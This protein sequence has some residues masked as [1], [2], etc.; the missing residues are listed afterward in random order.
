MATEIFN[1]PHFNENIIVLPNG[2]LIVTTFKSPGLLY[3][4]DLSASPRSATPIADLATRG[5]TGVSGLVDLGNGRIAV[6]GGVHTSFAFEKGSMALFIISLDANAVV[7]TIPVPD[8][9]IMNGMAPWPADANKLVA[10]DSNGRLILIDVT[11]RKVSIALEHESMGAQGVKLPPRV[12]PVGVNGV[13]ARGEY[14]Y[15]TNSCRGTFGRIRVQ[16]DAV[17]EEDIEILATFS[18]GE[19]QVN[20][21]FVFDGQGNAYVAVHPGSLRKI[22]PDW[23]GEIIAGDKEE[24]KSTLKHPTSAALANDGK[25]VYVCTGGSLGVPK[26]FG[27]QIVQV[28]I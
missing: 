10:A 1:H 13:R 5:I 8:T 28:P 6:A 23:K 2:D 20:D 9:A 14:L 24:A 17:N 22:T 26:E 7:A 18:T 16:G 11:T 21:D 19:G 3:R 27:G 25:S 12:P 4:V 15:F